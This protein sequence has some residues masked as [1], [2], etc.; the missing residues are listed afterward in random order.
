MTF[1]RRL[2]ENVFGFGWHSNG[3]AI[4]KAMGFRQIGGSPVGNLTPQ[5]IGEEVFDPTNRRFYKAVGTSP[6]DW[7]RMIGS[8]VDPGPGPGPGPVD[9]V[10]GRH[11]I[12]L[13]ELGYASPEFPFRNILRGCSK[14]R[15]TVIGSSW[16][17]WDRPLPPLDAN[18]YPLSVPEGEQLQVFFAQ[19]QANSV[20]DPRIHFFFDG[21]GTFTFDNGLQVISTE[22][23][24]IVFDLNGSTAPVFNIRS[25]G[26][27]GNHARNFRMIEERYLDVDSH[28]R[29]P[30]LALW[31]GFQT[32]RFMDW[33]RTNHSWIVDFSDYPTMESWP[34]SMR[35][36]DR[37]P[38]WE[39]PAGDVNFVPIEIMCALA[40][41]LGATP[42]FNMPH[43]ATPAFITAFANE[44]EQ[45][46]APNL[47]VHVE[48]SNEVWNFIFE[49]T[50]WAIERGE[51]NGNYGT[52]LD[53]GVR[54][55]AE[56]SALCVDLWRAAF[57]DSSRIIGTFGTWVASSYHASIMFDVPGVTDQ[58]D[59]LAIAPYFGGSL[60][61]PEY[62]EPGP[63]S[64]Y[65]RTL[66]GGLPFMFAHIDDM[67]RTELRG[68]LTNYRDLRDLH[69]VR[70]CTYEAGQHITGILGTDND[71]NFVALQEAANRDPRMG[72]MYRLFMQQ[73]E[74]VLG[75][76]L[77]V[78]YVSMYLSSKFGSW[79]LL[80]TETDLL[81][82]KYVAVLE[83][84]AEEGEGPGPEPGGEWYDAPEYALYSAIMLGDGRVAMPAVDGQGNP[85]FE[86][87]GGVYPKRAGTAAEFLA[88][89]APA[90]RTAITNRS[91]F[92]M[93]MDIPAN[94]PRFGRDV[95]GADRI[96]LLQQPLARFN[97]FQLEDS[98]WQLLD[99]SIALAAGVYVV[100]FYGSGSITWDGPAI[101]G[102]PVTLQ[103][104]PGDMQFSRHLM[105]TVASGSEFTVS[106]VVRYAN[107]DIHGDTEGNYAPHYQSTWIPTNGSRVDLAGEQYRFAPITLG[108]LLG[109]RGTIVIK[110]RLFEGVQDNITN[111]P[112]KLI[113]GYEGPALALMN[114]NTVM[115]RNRFNQTLTAPL[116][117][118]NTTA[119][120]YCV[121]IA[122]T[123]ISRR[124]GANGQAPTFRQNDWTEGFGDRTEF[125][126]GDMVGWHPY[127]EAGAGGYDMIA[128][129][130]VAFT[131]AQMT[132]ATT[133]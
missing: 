19:G 42:W 28:F 64:F 83:S 70:V 32:V 133:L 113:L 98:N 94:V 30:W 62:P 106:G 66:A 88:V 123:P 55:H 65:Q 4:G 127:P 44:V 79:G 47:S 96:M 37:P 131:T 111:D 10:A 29:P 12:G 58:I 35:P 119:D 33:M 1:M 6:A 125:M 78:W 104:T 115:T 108:M 91:P 49:Q 13:A 89:T 93:Q 101:V 41:E 7:R 40:N 36:A 97:R 99:D 76:E 124:V 105:E 20:L 126:L 121:A 90:G 75:D 50:A 84:I 39:G 109:E 73:W 48:H 3:D 128:L 100:T 21:E 57:T 51:A 107:A 45:H 61:H 53:A 22:P 38:M 122:W 120:D 129:S 112:Y 130:P 2:Y 68:W 82:P 18:G 81:N 27:G 46:L 92:T 69:E 16:D 5:F 80:E 63:N 116:G 9:P 23:G 85:I 15:A 59:Y 117:D 17:G 52:G 87:Q 95:E 24:H 60:G 67:I 77:I 72:D 54:W 74:D 8:A 26:T 14:L 102:G 86:P 34:N 132:A 56:R 114:D 43:R 110:G 11:G 71:E 25:T 118:G 103:G 31:E